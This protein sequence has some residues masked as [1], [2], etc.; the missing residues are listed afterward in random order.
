MYDD[1]RSR[2]SGSPTGLSTTPRCRVRCR[3]GRETT[4]QQSS[5]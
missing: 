3:L 1:P 4:V 5:T 2:A